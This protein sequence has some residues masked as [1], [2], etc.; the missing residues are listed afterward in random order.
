MIIDYLRRRTK[1]LTKQGDFVIMGKNRG[2]KRMNARKISAIV[3]LLLAFSILPAS[4]MAKYA[5]GLGTADKPYR[6]ATAANL[7]TLAATTDDY[8]KYFVLTANIDLKPNLP[9]RRL[10]TTAVI[11]PDTD[12][13]NDSFE[14]TPFIGVFDGAGHKIINLTIDANGAENDFLGLFG[15]SVGEIKNLTLE[16]LSITGG[17]NSVVIGG[18][19]GENDASISNCSSSGSVTIANDSSLIGGL[20]GNNVG[21][22]SGCSSAGTVTGGSNAYGFGG[23]VG[24][25]D[26]TISRCYSTCS[27][28][29]ADNSQLIGGLA[30]EN[31]FGTITNCYSTGTVAAGS[32]S[33]YL[34]GSV[35]HNA[36]GA[37]INCYSSGDVNNGAG[38]TFLGGLMGGNDDTVTGCYFLDT[39]GLDNGIGDP[40]TDEQMKQDANFVGWDFVDET[41]NGTEDIWWINEGAGYPTLVARLEI[42][43]CTITAGTTNSDRISFSGLMNAAAGNFSDINDVF[44]FIDSNDINT[45]C[46]QNFPVTSKT[47]K[48]GKYNYSGTVDRVRKSFTYDVKTR[49][50]AVSLGNVDLSG[51]DCPVNI[52]IEI[53]NFFAMARIDETIVNGPKVPIPILL[54]MGIKNTL[55]VDK[56][57]AKYSDDPNS[58][59]LSVKGAFAVQNID[60]NMANWITDD[61]VITLGAQ[62]FTIPNGSL[63]AGRGKFTFSKVPVT[64]GDAIITGEFNF[65]TRAFILTLKSTEIEATP[66]DTVDFGVSF[67]GFDE[68]VSIVLPP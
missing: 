62:T 58:D 9:G 56:L 22:V 26:G 29:G 2:F 51:L 6:I 16:N 49:K 46:D 47:F 19:V 14:G 13:S 67:A 40:L 28:A 30:G 64:E 42:D 39:S 4:V 36:F 68:T 37:V 27:V 41:A 11:A 15:D 10:F 31:A 43:K 60:P 34:G 8:D 21:D 5:G 1:L 23:L 61:L 24:E 57:L 45:P 3:V 52:A 65:N 48:N 12:N 63:K 59:Q 38:S 66:G 54:M 44:V 25:N 7:L 53:G 35:G 18:L 32:D 50:F 55:R 17:D 20:V 33:S